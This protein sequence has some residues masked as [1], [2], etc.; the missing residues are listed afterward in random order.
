M[1]MRKGYRIL[2]CQ[3]RF[4]FISDTYSLNVALMAHIWGIFKKMSLFPLF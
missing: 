3:I 4:L 1:S 2:S